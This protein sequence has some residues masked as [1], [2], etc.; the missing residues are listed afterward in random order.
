MRKAWKAANEGDWCAYIV[1]MGGP[2]LGRNYALK[3]EKGLKV[4]QNGEITPSENCCGEPLKTE[5][6][7]MRPVIGLRLGPAILKTY[8]KFWAIVRGIPDTS[9]TEPEGLGGAWTRDNNCR[10]G[11]GGFGFGQGPPLVQRSPVPLSV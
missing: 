1:A 10:C 5:R 4:G 9:A 2:F 7:D 3:L 11:I 8:M 6:W